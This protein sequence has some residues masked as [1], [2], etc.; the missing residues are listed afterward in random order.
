MRIADFINRDKALAQNE[1]LHLNMKGLLH[2]RQKKYSS[3]V[4]ATDVASLLKLT[5]L[6]SRKK[7]FIQTDKMTLSPGSSPTCSYRVR[8]RVG[9]RTWK[10]G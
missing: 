10:P 7:S 2:K 6:N 3:V 5:N 4:V 8:E 1:N 9:E